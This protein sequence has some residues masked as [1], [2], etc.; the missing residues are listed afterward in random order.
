MTNTQPG[1]NQQLDCGAESMET[2]LFEMVHVLS[3][4]MTLGDDEQT[5]QVGNH[6]ALASVV[7]F[8]VDEVFEYQFLTS[9]KI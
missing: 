2:I 1:K 8:I 9:N 3:E 5:Q 6:V 7:Y 4:V